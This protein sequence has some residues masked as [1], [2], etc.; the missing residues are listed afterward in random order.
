M[1]RSHNCG[2]LNIQN[3][4]NEVILSGWVQKTRDKGGVIWIDLRDRFGI[5]QIILEEGNV[6][7]DLIAIARNLGREFVLQVKGK[8]VERYSKN[9]QIA[10]GDIEIVPTE[11]IVLNQAITPPFTIEDQTDGGEE[12]RMK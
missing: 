4:G 7:S 8:V 3:V 10:T 9:N 1:Y 12:L 2:E 5:T 11:L 6:S